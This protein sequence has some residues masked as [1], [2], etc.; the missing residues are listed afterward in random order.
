MPTI[1]AK[2]KRKALESTSSDSGASIGS[3]TNERENFF[4]KVREQMHARHRSRSPRPD[5][6]KAEKG[7]SS[8]SAPT[9]P[10]PR[11]KAPSKRHSASSTGTFT[12]CG[13]HS[14]EWLFKNFS[15]SG[16][17]KSLLER[18]DS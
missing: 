8:K 10:H 9:S 12:Q 5:G 1:Q 2:D 4:C 6:S 16:A 11:P 3:A 15:F 14:N 17:V 7:S 13:R 18:R